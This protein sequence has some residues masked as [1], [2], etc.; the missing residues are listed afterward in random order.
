MCFDLRSSGEKMFLICSENR[1]H[2]LVAQQFCCQT[3][4]P[5]RVVSLSDLQIRQSAPVLHA[6]CTSSRGVTTAWQSKVLVYK[7]FTL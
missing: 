6:V 5:T 3:P 2:I 4:L 7:L 1:W